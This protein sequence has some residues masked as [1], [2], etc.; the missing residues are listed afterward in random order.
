MLL[1]RKLLNMHI[2]EVISIGPGRNRSRVSPPGSSST[3]V[4]CPRCSERTRDRTAQAESSSSLNEYSCCIFLRVSG[5]GCIEAGASR[6]IDGKPEWFDCAPRYRTIS[7][8]VRRASSTYCER[9]TMIVLQ[10]PSALSVDNRDYSRD[11]PRTL[12]NDSLLR[13]S[14]LFL[15]MLIEEIKIAAVWRSARDESTIWRTTRLR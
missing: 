10:L 9:S 12:Q 6:R 3:S 11:R 15:R 1:H 14:I 8:S 13:R 2:V 5:A 7:S 4:I